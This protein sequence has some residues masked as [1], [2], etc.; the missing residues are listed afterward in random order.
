MTSSFFTKN[1]SNIYIL[2]KNYAIYIIAIAVL[3]LLSGYL[4]IS[5]NKSDGLPYW[6]FPFVPIC[7][8][9]MEASKRFEIDVNNKTIAQSYFGYNKTSYS[10]NEFTNFVLTQ[11]RMNFIYQGTEIKMRFN[12]SNKPSELSIKKIDKKEKVD[13]LLEEIKRMMQG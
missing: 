1:S 13:L 3:L 2:K 4:F 6:L 10:F 11:H 8:A 12:S 7:L 5:K 9:L